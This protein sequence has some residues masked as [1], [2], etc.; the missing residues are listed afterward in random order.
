[1]S[2]ARRSEGKRGGAATPVAGQEPKSTAV[3]L[4]T[5]VIRP[6]S[7]MR[8][9]IHTGRKKKS[10]R[11]ARVARSSR[12]AC[13]RQSTL[14]KPPP[15]APWCISLVRRWSGQPCDLGSLWEG[16]RQ[17]AVRLTLGDGGVCRTR[18]RSQ[19]KPCTP[20]TLCVC[21]H[22][23]CRVQTRRRYLVKSLSLPPFYDMSDIKTTCLL[24]LRAACFQRMSSLTICR[25]ALLTPAKMFRRPR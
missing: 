21:T 12:R 2:D 23:G 25:V 20:C 3:R 1:M 17:S 9:I 22:R 16:E 10:W 8:V 15:S 19:L 24:F 4:P 18:T 13:W 7:G 14:K 5:G 6:A 11:R